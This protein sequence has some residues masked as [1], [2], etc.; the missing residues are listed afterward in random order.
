MIAHVGAIYTGRS[1]DPILAS[2]HR[3]RTADAGR[4]GRVQV[5][6]IGPLGFGAKID[7][8]LIETGTREQWLEYIPKMI[9]KVEAN[10][11]TAESDYLLLLQPQSSIQVPAK[12]FEYLQI[13]RPILAYAPK[14][15][16]IEWLLE[17]AGVPYE[18]VY[19][20]DAPDEI[21]A[22]V[23]RLLEIPTGPHRASE[24][25]Q[26]NFNARNQTRRLTELIQQIP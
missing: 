13:G 11:I 3:L 23:K 1:P 25:F 12:L 10:R 5:A 14:A 22:K 19:P 16:A 24:W 26:E 7:A 17:R 4:W 20:E 9:P 6:L 18:C 8:A 2:I 15:S 21:D